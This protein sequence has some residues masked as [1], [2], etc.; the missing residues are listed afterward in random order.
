MWKKNLDHVTR[1]P[2]QWRKRIFFAFAL[3]YI[4]MARKPLGSRSRSVAFAK[5]FF[6]LIF[7]MAKESWFS[8]EFLNKNAICA[9]VI[10]DFFPLTNIEFFFKYKRRKDLLFT[11]N[12]SRKFIGIS[13]RNATRNDS[14]SEPEEKSKTTNSKRKRK[15]QKHR[16]KRKAWL[17][18]KA[19]SNLK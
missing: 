13:P 11:K 9:A 7:K 16:W 5:F 6:F 12:I 17:L 14:R 8:V 18:S 3:H 19:Y 15:S 4:C 10:I 1:H 2:P